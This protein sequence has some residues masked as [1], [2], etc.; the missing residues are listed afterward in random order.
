MVHGTHYASPGIAII[1][2]Y[3]RLKVTVCYLPSN[4][5]SSEHQHGGGAGAWRV[6]LSTKLREVSLGLFLVE[7]AYWPTIAFTIFVNLTTCWLC[8]L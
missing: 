1:V 4:A 6:Q 8:S 2:I 7:S 3:D 5:H